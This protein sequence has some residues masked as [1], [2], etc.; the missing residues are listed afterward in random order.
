[1][2]SYVIPPSPEISG[3][4]RLLEAGVRRVGVAV[5]HPAHPGCDSC[6]LEGYDGIR[7]RLYACQ[8]TLEERFEVFPICA[9]VSESVRPMKWTPLQLVPPVTVTLLETEER[10][11]P[12]LPCQDTLEGAPREVVA[13]CRYVGAVRLSGANGTSLFVATHRSRIRSTFRG[14]RKTGEW[15]PLT[16]SRGLTLRSRRQPKARCARFSPRLNS[17]VRSHKLPSL[18]HAE[19]L[20]NQAC[21]MRRSF[22]SRC[23]GRE[24]AARSV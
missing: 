1:M 23:Y 6:E 21:T 4:L 16:T 24:V 15:H 22:Q 10:I 9:G 19:C 11:T 3:V 18:P 2:N 20:K 17:N 7:V 5:E 14:W 13:R 8:Q 12:F